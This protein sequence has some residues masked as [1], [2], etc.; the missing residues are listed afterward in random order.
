MALVT[1]FCPLT[2]TGFGETEVQV[3]GE[4]RLVV[5]SAAGG[6]GCLG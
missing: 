1:V 3:V 4:T 2:T 6:G 5:E